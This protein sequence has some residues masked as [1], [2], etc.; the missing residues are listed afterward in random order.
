MET[1]FDELNYST[2]AVVQ[3]NRI[4]SNTTRK[5]IDVTMAYLIKSERGYLV[6]GESLGQYQSSMEE[7]VNKKEATEILGIRRNAIFGLIKSR[8]L[9]EYDV[10]TSK[11]KLL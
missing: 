6:E 5:C 7:Y 2:P 3:Y 10:E 1:R 11:I 4:D 9:F 8:L